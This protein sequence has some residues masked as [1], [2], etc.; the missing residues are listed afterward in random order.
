MLCRESKWEWKDRSTIMKAWKWWQSSQQRTDWIFP[1]H[2]NFP[3]QFSSFSPRYSFEWRVKEITIANMTCTTT[4]HENQSTGDLV[5]GLRT[6]PSSLITSEVIQDNNV[7]I[8]VHGGWHE[9]QQ[10]CSNTNL[11]FYVQ[12]MKSFSTFSF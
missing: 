10:I 12:W 5:S 2:K 6:L 7:L 4:S 11:C 1:M 8:I 3:F 9:T